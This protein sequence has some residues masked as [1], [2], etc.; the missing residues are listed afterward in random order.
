MLDN[1]TFNKL[2]NYNISILKKPYKI[3]IFTKRFLKN[4]VNTIM[5]NNLSENKYRYYFWTTASIALSLEE[6]Y[7]Y[8]KSNLI[9]NSLKSYY[10]NWIHKGSK[11]FFIDQIMNGYTLIYLN[12]IIDND[13]YKN[14]IELKFKFLLDYK[15][16][17]T[18]KIPYSPQ[19]NNF[20]IE[21]IGNYFL[22]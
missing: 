14:S 3:N 4:S 22:F 5:F 10:D 1:D 17:K 19:I 20:Y 2:V 7:K 12:N 6:S 9:L 13:I 15:K 18:E 21:Y 8:N 16:K 11:I